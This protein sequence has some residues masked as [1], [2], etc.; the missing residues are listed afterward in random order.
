[1][2]T[3]GL[4]LGR[5][6]LTLGLPVS[7]SSLSRVGSSSCLHTS[8]STKIAIV[9]VLLIPPVIAEASW[10]SGSYNFSTPSSEMFPE[11]Q[12]CELWCGNCGA[13][14][15]LILELWCRCIWDAGAVAQM[16]TFG[17]GL[18]IIG[19][20]HFKHFLISIVISYVSWINCMYFTNINISVILYFFAS[21]IH[22]VF[23]SFA[24]F[25]AYLFW[26]TIIIVNCPL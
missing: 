6:G 9:L 23:Q 16:Y 17:A 25:Y 7:C 8:M 22:P 18:T 11:P 13:D 15:S 12:M 2:I 4:F 1:M 3:K 26:H 20:S 24:F 21:K 14:V 5:E 19:R 10:Y